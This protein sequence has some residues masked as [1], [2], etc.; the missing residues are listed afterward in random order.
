MDGFT[1]PYL[2]SR[3]YSGWLHGRQLRGAVSPKSRTEEPSGPDQP[4]QWADTLFKSTLWSEMRRK[5]SKAKI[6]EVQKRAGD[7]FTRAFENNSQAST[8]DSY[9]MAIMA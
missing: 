5:I 2:H 1:L 8:R 9:T 4:P 6:K 3:S 7:K